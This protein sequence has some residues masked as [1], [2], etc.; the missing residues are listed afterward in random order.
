MGSL[1][2]GSPEGRTTELKRQLHWDESSTD[3]YSAAFPP[4]AS[5]SHPKS[6]EHSKKD[7]WDLENLAPN[8]FF[9]IRLFR[10][11]VVSTL[12]IAGV[13][14]STLTY[15]FLRQEEQDNFA[16]TVS[17][18]N[19]MYASYEH[20]VRRFSSDLRFLCSTSPFAII[21]KTLLVFVFRTPS[22]L[23]VACRK[24]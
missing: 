3:I 20:A 24:P 1:V 13:I 10:L 2:F 7:G 12:L 18:R 4:E 16:N 17:K 9:R 5:K 15:K 6:S 19:E 21:C 22:R 23:L 8:I 14:S 11:V